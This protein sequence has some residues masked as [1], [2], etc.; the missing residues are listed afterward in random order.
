MKFP[1]ASIDDVRTYWNLRPCNVKHSKAQPGTI[2]Y[3]NDIEKRKYFV[4]PHIPRFAGF[5]QWYNKDV[6]EVGCGIGTDTMNFARAGA[7]V[8]AV[9]LS[10]E[11]L[12]IAS[13]RAKLMAPYENI[14]FIEGNAEEL[15]KVLSLKEKYDLVYSFGVLHH[16]PHPEEAFRQLR[17]YLKPDGELR[18]MVYNRFSTKAFAVTKGR[19]WR[20]DLI[21]KH[22][23]AQTGC[24]VTYS[25]TKKSLEKMLFKCGYLVKDIKIDHIFPYSIPEYVNY[26]YKKRW[27]WRI[28]PKPVFRWMERHFG[29]HLCATAI[30]NPKWSFS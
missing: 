14:Q 16:T 5:A 21:A 22:S 3:F 19:I 11:S 15:P 4:E 23:E 28:L 17:N 12:K 26:E 2:R 25:Y 6:L 20:D 13:Q 24:P 27:Y 29:W 1:E 9:D 30:R 8:V 10:A 7:R 18:I